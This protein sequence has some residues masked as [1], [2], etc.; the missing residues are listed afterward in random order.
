MRFEGKLD[1]KYR[2]MKISDY[3]NA[4]ALWES[5]PGMGLSGADTKSQI[6][7]FLDK[8]PHTC[9]VAENGGQLTGTVLGGND[10]RRGYIYHLAIRQ[11]IQRK[12]VAKALLSRCLQ[13]LANGGIQKCHLMVY[14]DNFSGIA[15]WEHNGWSIRKDVLT[16]SKELA[17]A[18]GEAE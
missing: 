13:A 11:D 16:M 12:G 14:H 17:S 10:G 7:K 3:E 6:K 1:I 8:N 15:F 9:W 18:P 5:L 2:K 4:I